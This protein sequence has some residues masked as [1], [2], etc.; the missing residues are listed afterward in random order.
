MEVVVEHVRHSLMVSKPK[1]ETEIVADWHQAMES[2]V[3]AYRPR[4]HDK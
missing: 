3:I 1:F 4:K 2:C